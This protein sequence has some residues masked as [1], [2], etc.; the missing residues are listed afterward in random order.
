MTRDQSPYVELERAA[1]AELAGDAPQ[2]LQP[3]EIERV[4][5][6]GDELDLEE[7][8]QVYLPMTQ[9]ISMRVR[10]AG[11]LYQA[12]EAF[13]HAPQPQ[14]TP[15]VIGIAGSVAVGKSTTARL[16]S[17]LL[18]PL[19][20]PPRRRARDHRRVPVPQRRARAPRPA[21]AQ[22]LPRVVRPQ[23]PAAVRHGGQVRRRG[24][25]GPG[26]L[27]PD[28]RPHRR[29]R[30]GQ[31]ART[32]SSSRASTSSRRPGP[33]ATAAPGSRSATSSTSR[34]TSTP[35]AG[36]SA[37][38][39]STASSRCARPRSRTRRRTSTATARSPTTRPRPAPAS[40]GTRSTCPTCARTSRPPAAGPPSSCA[41]APD[42]SV[43]WVRL[44][45]I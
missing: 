42:H 17:E 28:V 5:G 41:R 9:L 24:R 25:D 35:P 1:W 8:R 44:R 23:G 15:F 7:V 33:A 19:P 4:R 36:T 21:R 16:L 10:L 43:D 13:L 26:L 32:S 27:A 39:T 12:T 38:G 18:V 37:V 30:D 11:A 22:G 40:C 2:P 6:L 45:K 3:A 31:G 20:R 34:S 14:R 29:A